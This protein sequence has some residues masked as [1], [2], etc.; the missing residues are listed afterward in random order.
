MRL[1]QHPGLA[2]RLEDE[3]VGQVP[4]LAQRRAA[5]E[6]LEITVEGQNLDPAAAVAVVVGFGEEVEAAV[7][8]QAERVGEEFQGAGFRQPR[9]RRVDP[10]SGDQLGERGAHEADPPDVL[11]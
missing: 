3:G 6:Q 5:F 4:G 9:D 2:I 11:A 10:P 1:G 7:A 8:P